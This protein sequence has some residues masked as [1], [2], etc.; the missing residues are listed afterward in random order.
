MDEKE[1]QAYRDGY[2]ACCLDNGIPYVDTPRCKYSSQ[3]LFEVRMSDI[4]FER[5][6][7]ENM[8]D[9]Y[10]KDIAKRL[11]AKYMEYKRKQTQ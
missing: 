2:M 7:N 4:A 6:V 11:S 3:G 5:I 10:G 9:E 1:F 8:L